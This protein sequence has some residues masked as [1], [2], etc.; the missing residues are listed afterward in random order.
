MSDTNQ[1][2]LTGLARKFVL[3]NLIDEDTAKKAQKKAQDN[4]LSLVTHLV[5]DGLASAKDLAFSAAQEFGVP[6]LV[7]WPVRS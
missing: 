2:T 4:K 5:T 1:I 6:V 3:D 7:P